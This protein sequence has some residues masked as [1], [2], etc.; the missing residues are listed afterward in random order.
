MAMHPDFPTDPHAIIPPA[1]RWYPGEHQLLDPGEAG[2]LLPPLV[3]TIRQ[4]VHRWREAGY[5]GTSATSGALLRHWFGQVHLLEQQDGSTA[6]FSYYFAQREAVETAIWLYEVEQARDPYS[7]IRYDSSGRVSTGMFLSHW[8]RYV[9]KLATGAGKTKVL[10]LLI[11][12]SYFHSTYEDDSPLS[13]NFLLVAPNII[14]LDRLRDDFD[15]LAIFRHDPVLPPNG[16]HGRNWR[17]DF[18]MSLHIQ[19]EVGRVSETGNLF[20]TNI[21]RVYDPPAAPTLE[22]ADLTDFFLGK[23]P[24]GKTHDRQVDLGHVIRDISDLVVLNDEAHHIHDPGLA[25]FKA[26]ED[27]SNRLRQKGG[28]LAAQFDVTATPKHES[29]AIF[30]ETVCSYPLVEAIKQGVVKTP[31]I[32]DEASRGKLQEAPTDRVADRYAD[33]I[34][35]GYL[36]WRKKYDDFIK[37]G[38]KAVLF[39]MTTTTKESDEVAQHL[40]ETYPDL[41]GAVLVI[42]T[43][44]DGTISEAESGRAADE[45][46]RLRQAS[47]NI[48]DLSSPYK[49]VVS[50]LMLREGWDVKNVVSMVGLRP[51]STSAKIL[52]EQTL[53]RGLRRMFRGD[54]SITEYVSV[55]GTDLFMEFVQQ[56][57]AEGVELEQVPMG[58]GTDSHKPIVVEVDDDPD[59]DIAALDIELPVLAP[60]V[61]R[62]YRNLHDLDVDRM[63]GGDLLVREFSEA[64]QREIAFRE[65]VESDAVVWT[66]D[67]GQDITPTAQAVIGYLVGTLVTR[68]RLVGGKDVL[69]GR[70]KDYIQRRLFDREVDLNDTNVLRNLSETDVRRS[71][72]DAFQDAINRLTVTDSGTTAVANTIKLS[73]VRPHVV[74]RQ[75]YIIPKRS[76]FN[77]V[78]GDSNLELVFA[79]FLDG[80]ADIASFAKITRNTHFKIEF[81]ASDGTISNYFPDFAVKEQDGSIWIVETKGLEDLD[82]LPKWQRLV[83]WC[84]DATRLD[85]LGRA[86]RPMY[87]P[88]AEYQAKPPNSWRQA[89]AYFESAEPTTGGAQFVLA[90]DAGPAARIEKTLIEAMAGVKLEAE[91]ETELRRLAEEAAAWAWQGLSEVADARFGDAF[92]EARRSPLG[93]ADALV[94]ASRTLATE[95]RT[96]A[97]NGPVGAETVRRA[98]AGVCPLWPFC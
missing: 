57:N 35:L 73:N 69:Y 37:V 79:A 70:M 1:Y 77:R 74:A 60:R 29:G 89:V 54:P 68:M 14:V 30:V 98:L 9:F 32:P 18:Q 20:L 65:A 28:G 82:V 85:P 62:E 38:R 61:G 91:A 72:F 96:I 75:P 80:C 56:I 90:A 33:H 19:D 22:D 46:E 64:E 8:P 63:V 23:R 40:E 21:H 76:V 49:A 42:H 51:Y 2:K 48:D 5:P 34:K 59:K 44:R 17:D 10:S 16:Y 15:S 41:A 11:A 55:V 58:P 87:V 4:E 95:I 43:K 67:L 25:W 12:W 13:T 27:I 53:G 7:L 84:R 92:S 93:N 47:A 83:A 71:L 26:I 45:L 24:T 78:V 36:E 3:A 6:E 50:V 66:T 94:A 97:G 86:F 81:V 39:V 31:V 88:E 52:P